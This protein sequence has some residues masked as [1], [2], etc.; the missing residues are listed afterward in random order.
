VRRVASAGRGHAE[1]EQFVISWRSTRG[2]TM[3]M[4]RI[5]S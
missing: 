1:S 2:V 4:E 3:T 5:Q